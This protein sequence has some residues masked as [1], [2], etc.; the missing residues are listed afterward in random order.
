MSSVI[1]VI[2]S[3]AMNI[4]EEARKKAQRIIEE[5]KAKAREILEDKSYVKELED[6]KK[7]VEAKLRNEIDKIIREAQ[8]EATM[9]RHRG[10]RKAESVAK[11]IVSMIAA[12]EL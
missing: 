5:A 7:E 6:H 9:I 11:K 2:E 10:S 4:I 8:V 1:Q 12:I 3:E